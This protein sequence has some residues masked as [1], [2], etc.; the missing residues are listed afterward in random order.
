M[1]WS[2]NRWGSNSIIG[3]AM[4][5]LPYFTVPGSP[6]T[7]AF[8]GFACGGLLIGATAL[9]VVLFAIMFIGETYMRYFG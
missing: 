1:D 5:I 4:K 7:W 6:M 3:K 8:I 2:V 9:F